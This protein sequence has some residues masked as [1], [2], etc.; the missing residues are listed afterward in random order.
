[1]TWKYYLRENGQR[2]YFIEEFYEGNDPKPET[3]E[4]SEKSIDELIESVL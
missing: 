3:L 1:M 4:E 2:H